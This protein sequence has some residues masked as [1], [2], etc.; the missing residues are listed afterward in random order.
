MLGT[1]CEVSFVQ[2][3]QGTKENK[4]GSL[5]SCEKCKCTHTRQCVRTLFYVYATQLTPE[6]LQSARY[7]LTGWTLLKHSCVIIPDP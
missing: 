6:G 3:L 7:D 1:H 4:T 5:L 2:Q